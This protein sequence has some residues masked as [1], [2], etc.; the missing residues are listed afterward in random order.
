M[1]TVA[2]SSYEMLS[3]LGYVRTCNLPKRKMLTS[4]DSDS[5]KD[6]SFCD[7]PNDTDSQMAL[8]L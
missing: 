5:S 7:D 4:Y 3:S 6:Q 1:P 2:I 8:V